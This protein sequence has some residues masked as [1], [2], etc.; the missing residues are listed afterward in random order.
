MDLLRALYPTIDWSKVTF[1]EGKP[2]FL[3]TGYGALTIP[4]PLSIDGYLVYLG[5]DTEFCDPKQKYETLNTLVH[6]AVHILQYQGVV[7][8]GS[9]GLIHFGFI[10]YLYHY[11]CRGFN[12]DRNPMEEEAYRQGDAFDQALP[13]IPNPSGPAPKLNFCDCST[14]EPLPVPGSIEELLKRNPALVLRESSVA[15]P[16]V[17]CIASVTWVGSLLMPVLFTLAV[18][19][20]LIGFFP[21]YFNCKL[22]ETAIQDCIDWGKNVRKSC[23]EWRDDGYEDCK[24]WRDNSYSRCDSWG[25]SWSSSCCTWA[26]CKW[27]CSALVWVATSICTATTWVVSAVCIATF[28]VVNLVCAAWSWVIETQCL[29]FGVVRKTISLCWFR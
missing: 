21:N 28:W 7:K 29:A 15:A 8:S 12:Y 14:G 16:S 10:K 3:L 26:P 4:D 20:Y 25:V 13:N 5:D 27:V 11:V 18:L 24:S 19:A 9:P 1:L 6:E 22:V 23:K 2:W 17:A